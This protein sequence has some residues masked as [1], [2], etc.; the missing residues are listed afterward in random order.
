MPAW[1]LRFPA[2]VKP[3]VFPQ[4][5]AIGQGVIDDEVV[6]FSNHGGGTGISS[7]MQQGSNSQYKTNSSEKAD[8]LL[9]SFS[10][11]NGHGGFQKVDDEVEGI[12]AGNS[13]GNGGG[14]ESNIEPIAPETAGS[15]AVVAILS[16]THIIIAKCG[17]SR[18]VLYRGKEAMALSAD[19]KVRTF[20][21]DCL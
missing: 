17:D 10:V 7:F 21:L 8:Q 9:N 13:G 14:S 12:G 15:T 3:L 20:M 4:L 2:T 11:Y 6:G 5:Q 18:A 1:R 16:Q 19:H